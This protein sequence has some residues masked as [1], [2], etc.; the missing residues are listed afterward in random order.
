M[1]FESIFWSFVI[2]FRSSN[3]GTLKKVKQLNVLDGK[4]AQN[5]LILLNGT[6]K[7]IAYDDIKLALLR[8]DDSILSENVTEQ[9]IQVPLDIELCIY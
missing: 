1:L 9:L 7:H 5:I 8:C 6:L 3:S 2:C 4:T